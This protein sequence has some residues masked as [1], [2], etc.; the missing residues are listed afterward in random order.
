MHV[1]FPSV[2]RI[3]AD[4]GVSTHQLSA[5]Y[6]GFSHA[7]SCPLDMRFAVKASPLFSGTTAEAGLLSRS[8]S[9]AN[10]REESMD[11]PPA[12]GAGIPFRHAEELVSNPSDDGR[13]HVLESSR[14]SLPG[15]KEHQ[16]WSTADAEEQHGHLS[17]AQVTFPFDCFLNCSATSPCRLG[18]PNARGSPLCAAS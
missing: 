3:L 6:R 7:L 18:T 12:S 1:L 15:K 4:L 14:P 17:A 2:L 5:P 10:A 11:D 8:P 16:D 13:P 9:D